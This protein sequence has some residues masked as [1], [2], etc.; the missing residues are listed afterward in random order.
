MAK[1]IKTNALRIDDKSTGDFLF[2]VFVEKNDGFRFPKKKNKLIETD[3]ST[4]AI[5]EDINA[6]PP[7]E[8]G[9]SLYCPT[10]SLKEMRQI[11]LWAK[12]TGKLIAADEP[13]VFYEILDV[14]IGNSVIDDISGYRIEI[15]FVTNPFGYEINQNTKTYT[16]GQTITNHTNAPMYPKIIVHGN[17]N[18]QTSIKIGSQTIYLKEL[19]NK[20]TIENKPMEQNVYDQY[21]SPINSIMRGEF[22]ELPKDS[23][24]A[25]TLGPG[26][27]NVEI[28]ERWGWL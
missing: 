6:W 22:F 7:I 19:I 20:I 11:K 4:G 5:K 21:N 23:S 24:Q 25:I 28:L 17:S 8:K 27:T 9:Y 10:A 14:D 13:D 12:D 3:Y 18:S 26:I 15:V 16:S 1:L 2:P